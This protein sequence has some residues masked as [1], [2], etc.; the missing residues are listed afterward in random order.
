MGVLKSITS[1]LVDPDNP[2]SLSTRARARRWN[3]F[4]ATFPGLEEMEVLDL[5]GTVNYWCRQTTHPRHVTIVN[6]APQDADGSPWMST[7]QRDAC[8][9]DDL[10][11]FDLVVSNSV[12]EHV[13][14]H[15]QRQKLADVVHKSAPHH[16]IQ[17][18]YRYFPIEPHWLA[19][20]M[21][22]LPV[23][24]RAQMTRKWPL[25]HYRDIESA[26]VVAEVMMVELLGMTE[27]EH[28]FPHS[29]IWRERVAG[30]TKS[31]VAIA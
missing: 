22:F 30:L 7:H 12:I 9:V 4:Q 13:G 23:S 31:L 6:L 15:M 2:K 25:G 20:G 3:V 29:I 17:T 11:S 28:Y 16:W 1:A 21:Q 19:P 5:G 8:T 27:M 26:D 14:G 10:G 18:P 24:V